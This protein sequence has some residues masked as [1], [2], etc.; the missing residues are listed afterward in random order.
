MGKALGIFSSG[1]GRGSAVASGLTITIPGTLAIESNAGQVPAFFN[2]ETT[3]QGARLVVTGAPVDA[4]LVVVLYLGTSPTTS[5]FTLT[6]PGGQ[7]ATAATPLQIADC[8]AIPADTPV[9]M[10]ITAVGT[11]FPGS[12]LTLCLF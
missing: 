12:D 7:L 3:L 10:D 11:T 8:P 5:L 1:A 6:I 2:Q 4:D 9:L